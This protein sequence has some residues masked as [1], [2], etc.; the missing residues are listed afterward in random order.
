[1][2]PYV[3]PLMTTRPLAAA[4]DK[5]AADVPAT[6]AAEQAAEASARRSTRMQRYHA[7]EDDE[8]GKHNNE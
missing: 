3:R 7:V 1:A 6:N 5:P 8:N 4:T 2:N